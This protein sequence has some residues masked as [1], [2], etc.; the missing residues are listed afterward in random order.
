MPARAAALILDA[1]LDYN[2]RFADITRRAKRRFEQ[3]D[4]RAARI[5]ALARIDLYDVCVAETLARLERLLDDRVRSRSLW[6]SMRREYATLVAG[7][8]DRELPKTYFNT[9]SRRFFHTL[10]VDPEIEFVALDL[11]P[12]RGVAGSVALDRYEAGQDLVAECAR[13]LADRP[14]AI[15]YADAPRAAAAIAREIAER[16]FEDGQPL[17]AIELL[18]PV[19][20]RERR[21]Y[22][23]GRLDHGDDC[24]P[25]VIALTSTPKGAHADA[26]LTNINHVSLLFGYARNAFHADLP[27]V[28]DTVAFLEALMP[29]KPVGEIYSVLGRLKQGKTER[30]RDLFRHLALHPGERLVRA[31]GERGMVMAVFAPRDYAVV[32]KVIRDRFAYPKDIAR[33]QVE[34]KYRLVYGY[35]RVGRLV[36]AQEFR[37]LRFARQQF[38]ADMLAE[39]T[40]ECAETVEVDGDEVVLRHCYVERKLR[41]LNLYA[42]EAPPDAARRAVVDYGQAIK[43]LARSNVFPGDL[44]LKNFGVSRIGRAIFYDYD[45]I[46]LVEHCRFRRLPQPREGDET[47]PMEDWVS[48][49]ESDVFPEQFPRFLGLPEALRSA[50]MT[51]H[52][53]IFDADWWQSLKQ[54]FVA[55]DHVDVAPYPPSARLPE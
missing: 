29:H 51:A 18:R 32:V 11:D 25:L 42:R 38:D 22:F 8:L 48:Y 20:Y 15:G 45:E 26:V 49:N 24:T 28:A 53:E 35:D 21:A 9:L 13:L 16:T 4:W 43:D 34:E 19:F 17:R 44:L 31:D 2:E 6:S 14:F 30:Y 3:R 5:D 33:R 37:N 40:A 36:D 10:G 41:P 52:P 54:R 47:L 39:L 12:V 1:F 50:L 46:S 23:V 55:G 27:T 7:L